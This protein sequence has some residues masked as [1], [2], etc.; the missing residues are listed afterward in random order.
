MLSVS[1]QTLLCRGHDAVRPGLNTRIRNQAEQGQEDVGVALI[2]CSHFEFLQHT[3]KDCGF[4]STKITTGI[5][6]CRVCTIEVRGQRAALLPRLASEIL[7]SA[8]QAPAPESESQ[9]QKRGNNSCLFH[10]TSKHTMFMGYL[11]MLVSALLPFDVS[12]LILS[13]LSKVCL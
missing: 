4:S 13:L 8:P 9:F 1:F 12:C 6:K 10:C 7:D 11:S 5:G 3:S 2:G